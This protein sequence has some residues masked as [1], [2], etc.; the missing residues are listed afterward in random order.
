MDAIPEME[1]AD[2]KEFL[3]EQLHSAIGEAEF[4]DRIQY[5]PHK[6]GDV[7]ML[8][9]VGDVFPFMRV[10][11]LLEALQPHFSDIPIL[12]MYPGTFDGSYVRLFDKLT[13]NPYYR[14]FNE[15]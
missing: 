14:A 4:I 5:A 8:T 11:S 1:E 13:P 9:G 12:V 2:G 6:V 15:I 7:L 10:H 3:L